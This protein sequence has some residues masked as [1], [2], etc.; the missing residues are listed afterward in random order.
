MAEIITNSKLPWPSR[1]VDLSYGCLKWGFIIFIAGIPFGIAGMA[2]ETQALEVIGGLGLVIF[3]SSFAIS[4]IL[5]F[6]ALLGMFFF[7]FRIYGVGKAI[8]MVV[9]T[10]IVFSLGF[11]ITG[12]AL[13]NA[14]NEAHKI[15]CRSNMLSL[16]ISLLSYQQDYNTRPPKENWCDLIKSSLGDKKRNMF[17]CAKDKTGPCSYAMNENIP[18]DAE[19]LPDNLVLLF[20]SAPGWNQVGGMDDVVTDRHGQPGANIAFADGHVEFVEADNI[21]TLR[22]T[23][24]NRSPERK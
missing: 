3:A 22:W 10:Y 1:M 5:S 14:K 19:G 16:T 13:M 4:F 17:L 11:A 7:R 20:E 2:L 18:A 8:K 23:V 9:F 15:N 12:P 24:E 6:I 21:P